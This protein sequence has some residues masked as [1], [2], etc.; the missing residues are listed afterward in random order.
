MSRIVLDLTKSIDENAVVYFEK[1]KKIRKKIL[2]AEKALSQGLK[3]LQELQ[4]KKEKIAERK[5]HFVCL[6]SCQ[7][8]NVYTAKNPKS[9]SP[10]STKAEVDSKVTIAVE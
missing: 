8:K 6:V 1:A 5:S 3:R 4:E 7:F 9:V 2:G 10:K